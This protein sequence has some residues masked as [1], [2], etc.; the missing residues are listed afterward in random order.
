[1]VRTFL[2]AALFSNMVRTCIGIKMIPNIITLTIAQP[3]P[4]SLPIAATHCQSFR[5]G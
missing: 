4:M 3:Y 5:N 1:M 2:H